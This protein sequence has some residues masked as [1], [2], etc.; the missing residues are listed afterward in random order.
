LISP[1]VLADAVLS[2]SSDAIVVSDKDG[3]IQFSLFFRYG[4][5][6]R[7]GDEAA[8]RGATPITF[9]KTTGGWRWPAQARHACPIERAN[10]IGARSISAKIGSHNPTLRKLS[11]I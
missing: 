3:I 10:C 4:D 2:T 1:S 9:C 7:E 11:E 6:G 5:L 8:A